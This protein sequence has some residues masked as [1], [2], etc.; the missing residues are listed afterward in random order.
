MVIKVEN[1][2]KEAIKILHLYHDLLNLY[3]DWA[4]AVILERELTE[5]ARASVIERKSIGDDINFTDYDFIYIGSGTE[6]SLYECLRDIGR[7]K[8]ALKNC[9]ESDIPLLA[10]GNSHELFGKKVTDMKGTDY[11]ALG[12]LDFETTHLNSRVTGDI[13]CRASFLDDRLVGF[14]NRA[15]GFQSGD[16]QRPFTAEFGPEVFKN[17]KQEGIKHRN[18]LGTYM[19]GPILVRNPKLMHYFADMLEDKGAPLLCTMG[20]KLNPTL[21]TRCTPDP[22]FEYQSTA[23]NI[24]VKELSARKQK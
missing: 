13:I 20:N 24:T 11:P 5:R 17:V 1:N 9:V 6:R 8:D 12:L 4:N 3:G 16:I 23:Y 15:G 18:L 7:H 22:L 14:I 19:T 10:T 2:K 21:C